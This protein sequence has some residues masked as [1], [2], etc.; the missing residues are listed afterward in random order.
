MKHLL[1]IIIILTLG[2][3]TQ[4]SDHTPADLIPQD[5]MILLLVDIHVA[6]A[7]I[8]HKSGTQNVNLPLTNAI[9]TKIYQN[10][11]VSSAQFRSS[12]QYYESHPALMDNMY[13]QIITELSKKEALMKK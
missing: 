2:G 9:Y 10:Y 3:C 8:E 13:T 4:I 7:L 6:D 5:R 1:F 11:G 12:Y